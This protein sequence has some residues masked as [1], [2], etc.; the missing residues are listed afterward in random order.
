[1]RIFGLDWGFVV[2][3]GSLEFEGWF[4]EVDR[5]GFGCGCLVVGKVRV[6]I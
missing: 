1:M 3:M 2:F 6:G 5:V 4:L